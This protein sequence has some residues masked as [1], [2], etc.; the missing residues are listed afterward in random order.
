MLRYTFLITDQALRTLLRFLIG[1]IIARLC[2][3]D[4]SYYILLQTFYVYAL[5]ISASLI[6]SPY[7]VFVHK[8][9][10]KV[11]EY[12]TVVSCMSLI[13]LAGVSI[14]FSAVY[15]LFFEGKYFNLTYYSISLLIILS[16]VVNNLVRMLFVANMNYGFSA[17]N[18]LMSFVVFGICFVVLWFYYSITTVS[19]LVSVIFAYL[20]PSLIVWY[21]CFKKH[22]IDNYIQRIRSVFREHFRFGRWVLLTSVISLITSASFPLV[23]KILDMN[24]LISSV[25]VCL[26]LFALFNPIALLMQNLFAPNLAKS[27]QDG[28]KAFNQVFEKYQK[29]TIIFFSISFTAMALFGNT[30]IGIVYGDIYRVSIVVIV[31]WSMARFFEILSGLY[32]AGISVFERTDELFKISLICFVI[33]IISGIWL[34]KIF[35]LTGV[36]MSFLITRLVQSVMGRYYLRLCQLRHLEK[37]GR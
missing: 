22:F 9:D 27:F 5:Y 14:L 36:A 19:I 35:G 25:G 21:F 10:T 16:D 4:Y 12:N 18:S 31:L 15:Y 17:L 33:F 37:A 24:S 13:V 26:G 6:V 8:K 7:M 28:I 34:I 3:D 11:D 29:I 32:N 20:L 2:A 23:L 1:V 30:I